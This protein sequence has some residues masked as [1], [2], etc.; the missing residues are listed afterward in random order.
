MQQ[1]FQ[2][3]KMVLHQPMRQA[4][5]EMEVQ[6]RTTATTLGHLE[7]LVSLETKLDAIKA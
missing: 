4:M 3:L 7:W 2:V 5:K 6:T 1:K